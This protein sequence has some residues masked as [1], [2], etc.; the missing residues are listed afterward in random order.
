MMDTC[1]TLHYWLPPRTIGLMLVLILWR[2]TLVKLL[3]E[4]G[5]LFLQKVLT[6]QLIGYAREHHTVVFT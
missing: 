3:P 2:L 5:L 4:L 1:T 6:M